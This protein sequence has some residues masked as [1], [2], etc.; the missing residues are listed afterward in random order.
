M[1]SEILKNVKYLF[2]LIAK[3]GEW[4][5]FLGLVIMRTEYR[6]SVIRRVRFFDWSLCGQNT[7]VVS[8]PLSSHHM[9]DIPDMI[10]Q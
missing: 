2:A 7:D 6:E 10:M 4:S 8:C 1:G 9:L 3:V 5:T